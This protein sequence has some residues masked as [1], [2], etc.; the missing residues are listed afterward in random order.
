MSRYILSPPLNGRG[1]VNTRWDTFCFLA[2]T[3][4]FFST[5]VEMHFVSSPPWE[6]IS[7]SK[8][9]YILMYILYLRWHGT[10][11]TCYEALYVLSAIGGDYSKQVVLSLVN[12]TCCIGGSIYK[13]K[14][15]L[16]PCWIHSCLV[17][18]SWDK[19][20]VFACMGWVRS[21]QF[22]KNLVSTL[23]C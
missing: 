22:V 1:L 23:E 15:I 4:R 18:T 11:I 20:R 12:S 9:W 8:F 2:G 6:E 14:Y 21:T 17:N 5:Q 3:G 10:V 13:L 19:F 7:Q 16:S